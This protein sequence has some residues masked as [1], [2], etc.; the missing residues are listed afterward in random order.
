MKELTVT[1]EIN[2]DDVLREVISFEG[3]HDVST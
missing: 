2:V 1:L 3:P